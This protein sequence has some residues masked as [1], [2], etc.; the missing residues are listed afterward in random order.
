MS[1]ACS[2]IYSPC[3]PCRSAG[4]GYVPACRRAPP[5]PAAMA[6]L[7]MQIRPE[8]LLFFQRRFEMRAAIVARDGRTAA[9]GRGQ[10]R[11]RARGRRARDRPTEHYERV[12]SSSLSLRPLF[13]VTIKQRPFA[14]LATTKAQP[15]ST[16]SR[17]H[18]CHVLV[19]HFGSLS[20]DCSSYSLFKSAYL[21]TSFDRD[22]AHIY[23]GFGNESVGGLS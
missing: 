13:L 22:L 10:L 3:S 8:F 9:I 1:I 20:F 15:E 6:T 7:Y 17:C 2:T 23:T 18:V 4:S 11:A 5:L 12:R 14:S 19:F 21:S 16:P